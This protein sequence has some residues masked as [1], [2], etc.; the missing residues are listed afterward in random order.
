MAQEPSRFIWYEL[1]TS[2]VDAALA[3]YGKVVGWTEHDSH[4]PGM[5]YRLLGIGGAMVGGAM[6]M[7]EAAAGAPPTWLGYLHVADVDA[8]VA[9]II[10]A[11]GQIRMPATE[12]PNVGRFALVTDPQGAAFY[13]MTPSG[14]EGE[15]VSFA[16]G[17]NGHGGWNELHARD[18]QAALDF[19]SA[20]FAWGKSDEVDMGPAGKYLLFNTGGDAIGGI[21]GSPAPVPHWLY[22]FN[23][24]DITT[25]ISRVQGAGGKI[26]NGPHQVP[27]GQWIIQAHDPQGAAFALVS[28]QKS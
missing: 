22:Y 28:A 23:V 4:A 18:G 10:G 16:P 20:Q 17:K 14:G 13:V 11:G 15:S 8:S 24:D 27:G 6:R 25:A 26:D 21:F 3:F 19:Y 2:D 9:K 5:D 12:I 7:P 1:L